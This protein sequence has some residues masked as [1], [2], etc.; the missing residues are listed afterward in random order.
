MLDL[1]VAL[2]ALG[3]GGGGGAEPSA[4]VEV[5]VAEAAPAL[6]AEPQNVE[7]RF[8]TATEVRPILGATK[9]NWV[10]VREFNG[11]D[12]VYV[13]HLWSWRCGLVQIEFAVNGAPLEVWEMPPCQVDTAVP[14]AI[15]NEALP[16][17][18]FPLGSVN[19]VSVRITY[20]DLG[21]EDGNWE[22]RSVLMP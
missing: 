12:L 3:G 17:R 10:A 15:P 19:D 21:T 4:S 1:I 9:G 7:G 22:R 20:D 16:Y 5:P 13:T 8:T 2:I 18:A 14:N 11:Q 6:Q